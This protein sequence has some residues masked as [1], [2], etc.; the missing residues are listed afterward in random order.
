M[1][2]GNAV[3]ASGAVCK[4]LGPAPISDGVSVYSGRISAIVCS[5]TNSQRY[6]ISG[7]DGGVWRTID[8]GSTWTPLTDKMPTT[9]MGALAIDPT[10]EN[11]IYA[12]TGEANFA[13]H[14]RYGLGIYKSL[15]GGSTWT[16]LAQSTFAG[17]CFSKIVI[18]H[19]NSQTLYASITRAGGFPELAAAKGHPQATGPV[20]V[21][22]STDGGVNWTQLTAGLPNRSATDLAIDPVNPQIVYA[23]IG[24]I[25]GATENGIYKSTN[26]GDSWIKLA[27]GLPTGVVGRISIGIAHTN[28]NRLYALYTSASDA[29]GNNGTTLGAFRT[30]N[31]GTTW[32]N[33][34]SFGNIQAT[35]GWYLSAVSV[36]PTTP[37]TVF[38]AGYSFMRSTNAGAAWTNVTPPHVDLHAVAWD[39]TNRLLVGEDGGIVRSTAASLGNSWTTRNQGLGIIQFYAGLSTHPTDA[40]A[41][42]IGAQDN[43][44]NHRTLDSTDWFQVF[45]GDGG[46]TQLDRQSPNR[47]FVCYQGTGNLFLSADN[48][49][50]FDGAAAGINTADRNCFFP[51]YLID[52][53]DSNRML[54]ATHRIYRST[55]GSTSWTAI[56][57]DLTAGAGAIRALAMAPSNTQTVY[58][59]TNDGRFLRSTNGGA[60]FTLMLSG[61]LGWPRVTREIFVDPTNAQKVYLAGAIFGQPHVR[62][63]V[64]GGQNWQTLDGDLPDSPVNALAVDVRGLRPAIYAGSD[65]GLYRSIDDGHTW[66]RY[67][68]G[69]PHVPVIDLSL[70]FARH[71]AIVAT[72]GR[73]AWSVPI[74]LPGDMNDDGSINQFDIPPFIEA[75]TDLAQ[76]EQDHPGIDAIVNGDVNGDGSLNQ[77]D[78]NAFIA[79]LGG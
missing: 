6:F 48:G 59:A 39:S 30:D 11:V 75:L 36:H 27:G 12:G 69:L 56:S 13:N 68:I 54:Y 19:L 46:W 57:G 44:T 58:A 47:V 14:S 40:N 67:G 41:L 64:D 79:V 61:I 5:P 28:A 23:A 25:F 8:G 17:R 65:T 7:A 16:Q 78:I 15:D 52:P 32:T 20:G 66:R 34:G 76:Y 43:G 51:P 55:N 70:E 50:S 24:H 72:Q 29:S 63:S 45:G 35:Y 10:N 3:A 53:T 31:A 18:N 74:A 4:E 38:M 9:S 37:D 21:F 71:R 26:G 33:I 77:F 62:R 22:R 49:G 60:N 2:A 1:F 42:F 73:G